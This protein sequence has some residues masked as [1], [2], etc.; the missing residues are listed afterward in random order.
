MGT[1]AHQS[2]LAARALQ[3]A[4]L[5]DELEALL[6]EGI[7]GAR[8][9]ERDSFERCAHP[10]ADHVVLYGA[11]GLGRRTLLGMRRQGIDP[12]AFADGNSA[13]WG[14]DVEGVRVLSPED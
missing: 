12:I 4:R 7:N 14:T 2:I 1:V 13:L 5:R 3:G 6:A 9:R 10:Y 8:E 11:G